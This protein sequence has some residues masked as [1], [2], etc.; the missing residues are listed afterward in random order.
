MKQHILLLDVPNISLFGERFYSDLN[1]G[2]ITVAGAF[3]LA[4]HTVDHYDLNAKLNKYRQEIDNF[5]LCDEDYQ[6]LINSDNLKYFL[7]INE[8]DDSYLPHLTNWLLQDID[9]NSYDVIALSVTRRSTQT[10]PL[11]MTLHFAIILTSF[12]KRN[13][14]SKEIYI[15]GHTVIKRI[16]K[17][18]FNNLCEKIEAKHQPTCYVKGLIGNTDAQ[19]LFTKSHL[20]TTWQIGNTL[21]TSS[22]ASYT[23]THKEY[24]KP[25]FKNYSD[26][27][28]TPND[29]IP[30][31]LLEQY[32]KLKSVE[33]FQLYPYKFTDGCRFKCSFCEM[34]TIAGFEVLTPEET[35]DHLEA[36]TDRGAKHFRFFNDQI[37]WKRSWLTTFCNEIIKR[38]LKITWNDSANLRLGNEEIY[39]AMREAGCIKLWYGTETI[40]DTILK[41]IQ[42][43]VTS[44]QIKTNLTLAHKAEI[45]NCC[46]FIH[47]FPGETDEQFWELINFIKEFTGKKIMNGYQDNIFCVQEGGEYLANPDKFNIEILE[48][49]K[50][51]WDTIKYN[52]KDNKPWEDIVKTGL[53]KSKIFRESGILF[54]IAEREI[55][56]NDFI[57]T[58]LHKAN[59][60]FKEITQFYDDIPNIL[61]NI[62]IENWARQIG[63]TTYQ[64]PAYAKE[65][66]KELENWKETAKTSA[67]VISPD[68]DFEK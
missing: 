55:R 56:V 67:M 11:K 25:E 52:E 3:E 53:R 12:L 50:L 59:Y 42:K 32:S 16:G 60:T 20:T 43:N 63:N 27:L 49:D 28:V 34:A 64:I 7:E 35:V 39:N 15:G 29:F 46:N 57:L 2:G 66:V 30:E 22:D 41:E 40:N 54:S 51:Q 58:S 18:Y 33:P 47:N 6:I 31:K 61:T 62:E 23:F 9:I 38:N 24:P 45:W 1:A 21:G 14:E 68:I 8:H 65:K 44:A 37:N 4:G 17:K 13:F 10:W 5:E 19:Q 36:M 48:V 26:V